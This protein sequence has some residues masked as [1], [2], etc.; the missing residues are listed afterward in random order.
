MH[1][2]R[3]RQYGSRTE[4]VHIFPGDVP[5]KCVRVDLDLNRDYILMLKKVSHNSNEYTAEVKQDYF[6]RNRV[7]KITGY[8]GLNISQPSN[9]ACKYFI[10]FHLIG[11]IILCF[12]FI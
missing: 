2:N 1:Y 3:I 10:Q 12:L 8:C 5:K 11:M 6:S 9:E 7:D 4:N